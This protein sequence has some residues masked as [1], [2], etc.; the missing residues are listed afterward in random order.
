MASVKLYRDANFKG[1]FV[2]LSSDCKKLSDLN[3]NDV[4]SSVEVISGTFTLFEDTNFG[5]WSLTVSSKGG[6][7]SDGKYPNSGWI[8]DRNDKISSVKKNSD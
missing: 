5:G 4:V 1:G 7:N 8:A 3:F 2:E 6:Q